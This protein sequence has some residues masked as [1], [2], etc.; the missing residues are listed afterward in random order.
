M[1]ADADAARA[2][3]LLNSQTLVDRA[4][5]AY[6]AG[7]LRDSGLRDILIDNLRAA[8]PLGNTPQFVYSAKGRTFSPEYAFVASLFDALIEI[9]G[10][11]PLDAIMPF[12]AHWRAPVLILLSR[13]QGTEE[14]LLAIREG[15]L[16]DVEW[17]AVNNL[18]LEMKSARFFSATL[19]EIRI[20]HVFEVHDGAVKRE[21]GSGWGGD[22]A[23]GAQ[24]EWPEGFPP[25]G[26]YYFQDQGPGDSIAAAGPRTVYFRRRIPPDLPVCEQFHPPGP[27]REQLSLEYLR[28]WNKGVMDVERIFRPQTALR[29]KNASTLSREVAARL[30]EQI[31]AVQAFVTAAERN[32]AAGMAGVRLEIEPYLKD[33]RRNTRVPLPIIPR[34]E[35]T[36]K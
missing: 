4:W 19:R 24:P 34:K 36:L 2:R 18:L 23:S 32:G 31:A 14:A 20:T 15:T 16:A 27:N 3:E 9:R 25:V 11:V 30:N 22:C 5:G 8:P 13:Q 28:A 35:F 33:D 26:L 29:W 21:P 1:P 7:R 6:Y 12:E 10:V 17:R